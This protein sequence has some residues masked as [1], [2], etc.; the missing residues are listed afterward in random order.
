MDI[1][2]LFELQK[3][4]VTMER[5]RRRL[6]QIQLATGETPELEAA[7]SAVRASEAEFNR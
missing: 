1:A 4:D 6:G 2:K 5:L 7:R 3:Y